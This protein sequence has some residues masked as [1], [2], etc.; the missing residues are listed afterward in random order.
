MRTYN[1]D[2]KEHLLVNLHELA[3]PLF[4][5]G[6]LTVGVVAIVVGGDRIILV[7]LAPLEDL[8]KNRIINLW[9]A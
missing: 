8:A 2:L 5:I 1:N 7:M 4:D 9:M 3:V 6:G